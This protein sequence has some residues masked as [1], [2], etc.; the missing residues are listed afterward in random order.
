MRVYLRLSTSTY[1]E[2]SHFPNTRMTHRSFSGTL[3]KYQTQLDKHRQA[4]AAQQDILIS[5]ILFKT[6]VLVN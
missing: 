2:D 1:Q 3:V 4:K 5:I 6:Q